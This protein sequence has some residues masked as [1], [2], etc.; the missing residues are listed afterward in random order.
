[1]T[2]KVSFYVPCFN[3]AK[4]IGPCLEAVFKQEYPVAEVIVVDDGSTDE[5]AAIA[6]RYPVKLLSHAH[7]LGLAAARNTAIK[8]AKGDFIASVDADCCAQS[9]WLE[10]LMRRLDSSCIYAAGGRLIEN[11]PKTI[12]D[13]WRLLRMKQNWEDEPP[14][15]LFGSNTVFRKETLFDIGLYN[16]KYSTNYEDVDICNRLKERGYIFTYEPKAIARHLKNDTICSLMDSYWGWNIGYYQKKMYYLNFDNFIYKIKDNIGLANRYIEEDMASGRYRMLYL[17]FLLCLH[18]SL[19]DFEYFISCVSFKGRSLQ[20]HDSLSCWLSLLDLSFFYHFNSSVNEL[21][22]FIPKENAFLQNYFALS[23]ILGKSISEKFRGNNFQYVLYKHLFLS[24]CGL[25]D[26][27]LLRRVLNLIES[28]GDWDGLFIKSQPNLNALFLE[29]ITLNFRQWLEV[30]V[31]RYP[32]IIRLLEVS[33]QEAD[34]PYI[35]Y[36]KENRNNENR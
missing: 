16:E 36:K 21:P 30:L 10:I 31:S 4:T 32:E 33:A 24:I 5:S 29:N 13:E 1:M 17:D 7:N 6:S 27:H 19:R 9:D 23:L 18:H 11:K 28:R 8:N 25:S 22:T 3:A 2:S 15:F 20:C 34:G 14:S 35:F 12:F 26:Q